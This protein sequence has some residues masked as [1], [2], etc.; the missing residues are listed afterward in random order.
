MIH[1]K[2]A[3]CRRKNLKGQIQFDIVSVTKSARGKITQLNFE[4]RPQF[5]DKPNMANDK[6]EE[7]TATPSYFWDEQEH[8]KFV[9]LYHKEGRRWKTIA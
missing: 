6:N 8:L 3:L 9:A 2:D 1:I 4:L 7:N 5:S